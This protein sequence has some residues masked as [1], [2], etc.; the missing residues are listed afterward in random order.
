MASLPVS[1]AAHATT[2]EDVKAQ[3]KLLCGVNSRLPG[4]AAKGAD[5]IWAGLELLS[6]RL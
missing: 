4:F 2:L 1:A 5:G 3:S 6:A